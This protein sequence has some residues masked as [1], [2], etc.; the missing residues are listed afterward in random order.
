MSLQGDFFCFL[1]AIQKAVY[2]YLL[3]VYNLCFCFAIL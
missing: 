2:V 3:D 1:G